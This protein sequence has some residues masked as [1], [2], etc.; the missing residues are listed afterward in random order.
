MFIVS[1]TPIQRGVLRGELSFFSREPVSQ[2]AIVTAPVRG[3]MVPALVLGSVDA[4]E[5]KLDLKSAT[6]SLKKLGGAEA[7]VL[8]GNSA[9]RAV[10]RA[11]TYTLTTPGT[12]LSH[13]L[14]SEVLTSPRAL[15]APRESGARTSAQSEVLVLQAEQGERI[16][17]YRSIVRE[18]FAR[19]KSVIV[20]APSLV[21]VDLLAQELGR[22]IEERVFSASSARGARALRRTWNELT[23]LESPAVLVGTPAALLYPIAEVDTIIVE[24]E[25]ARAYVTRTRSRLDLR[26]VAEFLAT[27]RGARLIF[28]DFPLRTET[29]ARRDLGT[30]HEF[31]RPQVRSQSAAHVLVIDARTADTT[32]E[33]KRAF[34]PL[35]RETYERIERVLGHGGLVAIYA[36]R[37]GVAPLTVCNDCGTPITD[38][39]TGVPMVLHK[40]PRG[41]VFV[42]HRSG[43]IEPAERSCA[44]CGGWNLVSLGIG[45]DRVADDLKKKVEGV[46]PLIFTADTVKTHHAAVRLIAYAKKAPRAVL[47]G[48]ERMLPYLP[49]VDLAVVAS[50]DSVLSLGSWRAGEH[51]HTTLFA[52]LERTHGELVIETRQPA[53]RPI[54]SVQSKAP[55]E[56]MR[57]EVRERKMYDYPPFAT[58][59]GLEWVGK[60]EECRTLAER[61][62]HILADDD[63]VGPL[64]PESLDKTRLLQRAVVRVP[65]GTWPDEALSARLESLGSHVTRSVDPDDIV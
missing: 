27:E 13:L 41:T 25:S 1:V 38:R 45:I 3:K 50:I 60:P 39:A 14:F 6:F 62:S 2:G 53:A 37:K 44:V 26:V 49:P 33:T 11:A 46:V 24:R 8:V 32:R 43:A 36:A 20:I 35:Q 17:T 47:V 9:M 40:T 10:L 31:A 65:L 30:A 55:I 61:V 29:W 18:A 34:A 58:F 54:T 51:A 15:A 63:L 28:A 7:R 4:R 42:S 64:P 52:L 16:H 48:T 56:F 59:I 5:Q 57:E 22:G 12:V 21:E 19:G 23:E